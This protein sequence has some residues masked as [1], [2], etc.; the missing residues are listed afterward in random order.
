MNTLQ[1]KVIVITGG[2]SG[3]GLSAAQAF[4]NEGAKVAIL[5]R[6]QAT[7]DRAV[8][9]LGDRAL[10][11]RGNVT[12]LPDLQEFAAAVKARFGSVDALFVNAGLG[13]FAPIESV[14]ETAYD[15]QFDINVKGAFFTVQQFLPLLKEG[16]SV[17][18]TASSVAE[19]G[20][21]HGSLYFASKAAVRSFARTLAAE[22]AP[23][24]IRVNTLS[25]GIVRT[26]FAEKTNLE[27]DDFEGFMKMVE[28]QTPLGRA[29]TADE[30][31]R[32]ARFLVSSDSSYMT[33]ADLLVDGGWA[34]V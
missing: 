27:A 8:N 29:G 32:A 25:P 30:I 22:L 13:V 14:D 2:N 33:G 24:G 26:N 21:P 18:L 1:D 3:I 20:V 31:A 4:V 16:A 23:R 9:A 7:L 6:D 5:G 15:H 12:Q 11:H 10:G 17:V 19:K 28:S 34:S